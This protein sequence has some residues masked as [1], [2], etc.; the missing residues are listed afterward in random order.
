[1][2]KRLVRMLL[3]RS[4]SFPKPV[5][6]PLRERRLPKRFGF[7]YFFSFTV[8]HCEISM[9]SQNRMTVVIVDAQDS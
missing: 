2:G 4:I 6:L 5:R 3:L 7:A 8:H 1:M 9:Q